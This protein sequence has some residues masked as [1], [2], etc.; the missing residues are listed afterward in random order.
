M[1]HHVSIGVAGVE[2]AAEFYDAVL[3]ALG[4][5]RTAQYLPYAIAYGEGVSEFWIQLPHDN[6]PPKPGNGAH[7]GFTASSQD[8][9]HRFHE[10]ALANGGTD[11]GAPGPRPQYGPDYYG[12]FVIDPFGNKIEA[13]FIARD[14]RSR[15][16]R[17]RGIKRTRKAAVKRAASRKAKARR[18][19]GARK[20]KARRR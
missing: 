20:R 14:A 1:L 12:A 10:T 13:T 2:R 15:P 19:T 16:R 8:A 11:D 7:Y 5:K 17:A 6:N 9:V 4:Y 18:A 3:G